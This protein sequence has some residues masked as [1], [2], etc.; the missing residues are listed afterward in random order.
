MLKHGVQMEYQQINTSEIL[1]SDIY[2]KYK[3][4]CSIIEN[5]EEIN[6]LLQEIKKLQNKSVFLEYNNDLSFLEVEKEI[7]E[8]ANILNS[9]E[10]YK[11]Y[12]SKMKELNDSLLEGKNASRSL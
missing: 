5:D 2:S 10:K 8:K 1:N 4:I 11:L 6:N 12:L 7:L 9:N 3:E